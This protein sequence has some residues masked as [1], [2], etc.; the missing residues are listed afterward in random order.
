M[1][2]WIL[3]TGC[4]A[5]SLLMRFIRNVFDFELRK[6]EIRNDKLNIMIATIGAWIMDIAFLFW[7]GMGT[8]VILRIFEAIK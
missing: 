3:V 8:I 7:V 6:A 1:N 2:P 5:A 4:L